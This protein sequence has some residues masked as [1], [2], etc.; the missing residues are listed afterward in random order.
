MGDRHLGLTHHRGGGYKG[1]Q[2]TKN[3]KHMFFA[4]GAK[5]PQ[6]PHFFFGSVGSVD[7]SDRSIGRIGRSVDRSDRSDRS[8]RVF[9]KVK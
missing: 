4:G 5:P 3:Y 2:K 9:E 6:T 7:R 1:K 8:D